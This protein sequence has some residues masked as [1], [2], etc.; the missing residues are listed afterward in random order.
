MRNIRLSLIPVKNNTDENN[1]N[2]IST[3]K[4]TSSH[5]S[6]TIYTKLYLYV[7][8]RGAHANYFV[9]AMEILYTL[10]SKELVKSFQIRKNL[11]YF[12]TS[13]KINKHKNAH[14]VCQYCIQILRLSNLVQNVF[15]AGKN[16]PTVAS[17]K[18]R[19]P[20]QKSRKNFFNCTANFES[21]KFDLLKLPLVVI[22]NCHGTVTNTSFDCSDSTA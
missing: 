11:S 12:G 15:I 20:V 5:P 3:S 14:A 21:E 16:Y 2:V 9:K 1:P 4:K 22:P 10:R 19:G 6:S 7:Y 13:S 18:S 8:I 17:F